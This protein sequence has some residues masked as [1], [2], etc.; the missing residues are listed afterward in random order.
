MADWFARRGYRILARNW[1]ARGGE[2]DLVVA[3]GDVVAFVE[4]RSVSRRWLA[5]P[6]VTVTPRKQAR[7][8]AAADQY[9]RANG[10]DPA[11]IRFDVAGVVQDRGDWLL[12][13]VENA[14]VPAWSF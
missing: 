4:V 8:A 5:S 10:L 9:L 7:V 14:F 6:T 13:L 12:E 3:R 2:L 11:R 1:M